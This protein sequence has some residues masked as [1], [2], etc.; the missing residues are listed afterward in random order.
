MNSNAIQIIS[1]F[2]KFKKDIHELKNF[3]IKYG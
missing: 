1:N 2:E 3:E